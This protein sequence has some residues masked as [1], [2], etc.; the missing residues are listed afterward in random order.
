MLTSTIFDCAI[1]KGYG[2][3]I[4]ARNHAPGGFA[5]P[6]GLKDVGLVRLA[7]AEA[8]VPMPLGSLLVDQFRSAANDPA[9]APLDWSALGLHVSRNA[10]VDVGPELA[11]SR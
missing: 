8:G 1:Y 9:L 6:H 11:K 2:G 4:A 7:A 5:L 10:G 3:R